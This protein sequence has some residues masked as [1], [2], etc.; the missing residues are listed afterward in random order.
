MTGSRW[1]VAEKA[2]RD[3]ARDA[4]TILKK[5]EKRG[6]EKGKAEA[7]AE[8]AGAD[9]RR[10]LLGAGSDVLKMLEAR[11]TGMAGGERT[12][13]GLREA[14]GI[15]DALIEEGMDVPPPAAPDEDAGE[16]EDG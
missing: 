4:R 8:A 12:A 3:L 13:N 14:R 7:L 9:P 11:A 1:H 6:Y 5:A 2:D 15:L 10:S 16:P